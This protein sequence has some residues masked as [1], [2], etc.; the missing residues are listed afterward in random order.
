MARPIEKDYGA[1]QTTITLPFEIWEALRKENINVSEECAK[2]LTKL[3]KHPGFKKKQSEKKRLEDILKFLNPS[4]KKSMKKRIQND[5]N[6]A[7]HWKKILKDKH[8]IDISLDDLIKWSF[9]NYEG[10]E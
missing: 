5:K 3:I 4:T 2:H 10:G 6:T 1:K 8:D 7:E 9:D